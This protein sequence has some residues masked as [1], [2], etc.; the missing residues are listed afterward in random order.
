MQLAESPARDLEWIVRRSVARNPA[1]RWQSMADVHALLKRLAGAGLSPLVPTTNQ[2]W[3]MAAALPALLLVS[4]LGALA[5]AWAGRSQA[6]SA[7]PIALSVVP[8]PGHTFAPTEGSVTSA[9][10][11]LSPDGRAL[12]FVSTGSDGS[13]QLWLRRL[14]SLAPIPL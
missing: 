7:E 5:F 13:R 9:Q 11:A 8:P 6:R 1:D 4:A 12:V 3:W 2:S 14:S 10:L